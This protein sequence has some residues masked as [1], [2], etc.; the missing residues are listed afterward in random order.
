MSVHPL[1]P[2]PTVNLDT[3]LAP[4]AGVVRLFGRAHDVQQL[5]GAGYHTL[6][7]VETGAHQDLRPLYAIVERHVPSLTSEELERLTPEVV[8]AILAIASGRI[9]QVEAMLAPAADAERDD[10]NG[11]RREESTDAP[12]A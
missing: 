11:A 10:P 6:Y 4:V 8:G 7:V 12:P 3:L 2:T 5:D 9:R 1:P